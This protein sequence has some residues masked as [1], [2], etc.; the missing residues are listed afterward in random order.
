MSTSPDGLGR[1]PDEL[2]EF[3][4]P[5]AAEAP[6]PTRNPAGAGPAWDPATARAWD[7][8]DPAWDPAE[9]PD[10]DAPAPGTLRPARTSL[11]LAA[12][13]IVAAVAGT[14]LPNLGLSTPGSSTM[15]GP[16]DI[17]SYMGQVSLSDGTGYTVGVFTLVGL[18][19]A[20]LVGDGRL[21]AVARLASPAVALYALTSMVRIYLSL[22][23]QIDRYVNRGAGDRPGSAAELVLEPGAYC[24]VLGI[25]LLAAAVLAAGP[26]PAF[27]ARVG[28]VTEPVE[29][30]DDGRDIQ[31]SVS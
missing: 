15:A 18:L 19:V 31:V 2:P 5:V 12:V 14:L 26:R 25:L 13:G 7:P 16:S 17:L 1:A 23:G 21:N 3:H 4:P 30:E 11:V 27:L 28:R 6:D 10:P 29:L 24:A 9:A 20:A 22:D 8:A